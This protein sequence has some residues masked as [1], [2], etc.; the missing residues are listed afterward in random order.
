M[1]L[2]LD[3][4][5]GQ[6][7]NSQLSR[8]WKNFS[9]TLPVALGLKPQFRIKDIV[10]PQSRDHLVD[11]LAQT[12]EKMGQAADAQEWLKDSLEFLNDQKTTLQH[13]EV[14]IMS[15]LDQYAPHL[16]EAKIQGYRQMVEGRIMNATVTVTHYENLL[17]RIKGPAKLNPKEIRAFLEKPVLG[18]IQR[19]LETGMIDEARLFVGDEKLF[20][21]VRNFLRGGRFQAAFDRLGAAPGPHLLQSLKDVMLRK[22]WRTKILGFLGGGLLLATGLYTYFGVGRNFGRQAN[23]LPANFKRD[24]LRKEGGPWA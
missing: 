21:Q 3:Q 20:Q 5:V 22:L 4:K 1:D 10:S 2:Y 11:K 15:T 8:W 13:L 9:Q 6:I 24:W 23:D 14:D 18:E 19:L 7:S 16:G 12:L 17:K